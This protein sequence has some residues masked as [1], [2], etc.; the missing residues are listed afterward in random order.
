MQRSGNPIWLPVLFAVPLVALVACSTGTVDS[1]TDSTVS[2]RVVSH[3]C[4][5]LVGKPLPQ[6]VLNN[7]CVETRADGRYQRAVITYECS[8]GGQLIALAAEDARPQYWQAPAGVVQV[9]TYNEL[10][11]AVNICG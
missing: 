8:A 11:D 1:P 2:S 5:T 9:G 7:G 3:D 6:D 4:A 10:Q